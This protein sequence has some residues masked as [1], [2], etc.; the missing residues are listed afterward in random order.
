MTRSSNVAASANEKADR[1]TEHAGEGKGGGGTLV[2]LF[3]IRARGQ[4]LSVCLK[5]QMGDLS[6]RFR[7]KLMYRT[8]S[9]RYHT[10]FRFRSLN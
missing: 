3:L 7:T 10:L 1:L 4:A 8:Q 5:I 9:G 6:Q 2:S